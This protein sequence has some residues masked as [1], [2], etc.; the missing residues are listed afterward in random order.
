MGNP[1]RMGAYL[2]SGVYPI[3]RNCITL[4]PGNFYG[5]M[6]IY[7]IYTGETRKAFSSL[8]KALI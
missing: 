6:G 3:Q 2:F 5:R 8:V 4:K 7:D 1:N